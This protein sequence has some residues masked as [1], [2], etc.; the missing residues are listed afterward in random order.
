VPDDSARVQLLKYINPR[1]ASWPEAEFIVGNP[2]FIGKGYA[3]R[4]ALGDGYVEALRAVYPEVPESADYVMYWWNHAADLAR[5]GKVL[6]FGF[7]ATNS[8]WQTFNRRVLDRHLSAENPLSIVFAIPDHPWVDSADGAAVRISMTVGEAGD[9][10]GVLNKVVREARG[11]SDE[12]E[13][14]LSRRVGKIFS[15]LSIGANVASAKKLRFGEGLNYNGMM[16]NGAG[17]I[18][19]QDQAKQLGL[20]RVPD[21]E[22]HIRPYRNGRDLTGTPRMVMIIDLYG[23]SIDEVRARFPEIYNWIVERVK[24]ERDQNKDRAFREKWWLFGRS[25]PDLRL[26]LHGLSRYIATVETSKHRFFVFLDKSIVPDHMLISIALEDAH[27]LGVLS[28]RIHV[29]WALA[30]GGRLGVGNDPRYNKSRCFDTFPFPDCTEEHKSKIRNLAELLDG[31]RKRQQALYPKL[32]VTD[33][34]NVLEKLRAG[35]ALSEK[36]KRI[37][38][39]GLISG[40]K[41]IHDDLDAAVFDAYGWPSNLNDDEILERLV[42]L[43]AERAKEEQNGLVRWLRPEFQKPQEP[44]QASL[45][46]GDEEAAPAK[47]R[48]KTEKT[49]WPS[50]LAEQVKAVHAAL[51][52][53]GGTVTPEQ[54]AKHFSRAKVNRVSELLETL[55]SLGQVREVQAGRYIV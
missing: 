42:S 21:V 45:D 19:T 30:A 52:A 46:T 29:T 38:E 47:A 11:A 12:R 13:V 51:I 7:I 54:L 14:E 33:M 39:Q 48:A 37:N 41:Q 6:R 4:E 17:F 43:N 49:P 18:I 31:H 26:A 44:S 9:Y 50:G 1:R 55:A 2:P 5:N 16:I 34:Y 40:L 15:D 32:T 28:S 24:P 35:N 53:Q 25:R 23:L 10:I 22:K 27:Y 3:I 36:D 8:L 20:G